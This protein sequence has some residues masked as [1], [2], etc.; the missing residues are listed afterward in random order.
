MS[1]GIPAELDEAALA[2]SFNASASSSATTTNETGKISAILGFLKNA[3]GVKDLGSLRVSLP[4][5]VCDPL[6]FLEHMVLMDRPEL[7]LAIPETET[8]E[9]RMLAV[10]R[11]LLSTNGVHMRKLYKSYNPVLGERYTCI[12]E[13]EKPLPLAMPPQPTPPSSRVSASSKRSVSTLQS[14]QETVVA[15]SERA[16]MR[17]MPTTFTA[18]GRS[19]SASASSSNG[20]ASSVP[21]DD[22][23]IVYVTEQVSHHP[24]KMAF[25]YLCP[26][27]NLSFT[28]VCHISGRFTGTSV[29]LRHQ[30][31]MEVQS[32]GETYRATFPRGSIKGFV[33][34]SPYVQLE[35]VSTIICKETGLRA[36]IHYKDEVSSLSPRVKRTFSFFKPLSFL[37]L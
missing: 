21:L 27:R 6:S 3:I 25:A 17:S 5:S 34:L 33:T 24:P 9:E 2:S 19:D 26:S 23:K 30:Y 16:S 22:G 13:P 37:F 14:D 4:A 20:D 12:F 11:F 15:A 7:F 29:K 35:D 8:A 10:V 1:S 36:V 28:G 31:G 32:N 18:N